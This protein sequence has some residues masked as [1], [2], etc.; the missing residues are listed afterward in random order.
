MQIPRKLYKSFEVRWL[1]DNQVVP[2]LRWLKV[3]LALKKVSKI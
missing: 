1:L 3:G 2:L